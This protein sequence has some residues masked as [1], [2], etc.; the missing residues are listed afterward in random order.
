MFLANHTDTEKLSTR[1]NV[2]PMI[3]IK[4]LKNVVNDALTVRYCFANEILQGA[5]RALSLKF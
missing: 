2:N 4:K 1:K 5:E 3:V